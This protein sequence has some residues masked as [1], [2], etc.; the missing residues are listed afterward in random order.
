MKARRVGREFF[1][2]VSPKGQITL[3]A[4]V[5]RELGIKPGDRVSICLEHGV[6]QVK[7]LKALRDYFQIAP[8]LDPPLDWKEVE[9]IAHEDAAE[10]AAREGLS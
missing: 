3:P 9:R 7:R 1:S 4:D 5:R 10:E 6:V 8:A 2:S